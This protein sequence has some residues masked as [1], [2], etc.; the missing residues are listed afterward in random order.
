MYNKYTA[1]DGLHQGKKEALCP[2]GGGGGGDDDGGDRIPEK[3]L[4][5]ILFNKTPRTIPRQV[6]LPTRRVIHA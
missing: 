2:G 4:I 3:L 5:S 6:L 1:A